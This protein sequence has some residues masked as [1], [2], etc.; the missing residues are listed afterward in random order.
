ME[1]NVVIEDSNVVNDEDLESESKN[2][3]TDLKRNSSGGI[4]CILTSNKFPNGVPHTM[5]GD[6]L[7]KAESGEL[8]A[9]N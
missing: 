3:Y 5:F 9:I 4:D 2:Q 8:G 6:D 7:A 1:S